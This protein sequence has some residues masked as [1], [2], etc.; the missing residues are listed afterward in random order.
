MKPNSH[1]LTGSLMCAPYST[2]AIAL[3]VRPYSSGGIGL[4]ANNAGVRTLVR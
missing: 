2:L 3:D 1:F 4:D